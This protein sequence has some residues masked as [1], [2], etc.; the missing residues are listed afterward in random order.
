MRVISGTAG[1][2]YLK[3]LSGGD[4]VRPTTDRVKEA[5]FSS[6]QFITEGACFLD[7][8]SGSGQIGIEALSRG[9][10]KAYF[11]DSSKSSIDVIKSNLKAVNFE[12][13]AVV[14]HSDYKT[15]LN[16]TNEKFDII[17]L[18]PPYKMGLLQESL[19]YAVK[20]VS[21]NGRI[22]CEC[23]IDE[24][25]PESVEDFI[26]FRKYKYGNIKITAYAHPDYV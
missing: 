10:N 25:L 3:T 11:I 4:I 16:S 8:F 26:A 1:G 9:A 5:V 14:I 18:D 19:P 20:C 23:P 15:F 7:L 21:K 22:L 13:K 6:I 17:F 24:N 12:N 2:K